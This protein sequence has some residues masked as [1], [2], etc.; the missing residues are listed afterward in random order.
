MRGESFSSLRNG[1]RRH[2]RLKYVFKKSEITCTNLKNYDQ[3]NKFKNLSNEQNALLEKYKT[4]SKIIF[5][6]KLRKQNNY[7]DIDLHGFYLEEALD[8][9]IDQI[10]YMKSKMELGLV[11]DYASQNI[12]KYPY[13]KYNIITGKGKNSQNNLPVLLPSIKKLFERKKFDFK[14]FEHEGRIEIYIPF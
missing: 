6:S 1:V 13:L 14:A 2:L 11:T 3:A 8:I 7:R 9:V 5:L 10:R 12:K 4:A